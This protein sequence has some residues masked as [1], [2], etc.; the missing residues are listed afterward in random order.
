ML[1]QR[2]RLQVRRVWKHIYRSGAK[3]F[4]SVV[5]HQQPRTSRQRD[6]HTF[7]RHRAHYYSATGSGVPYIAQSILFELAIECALSDAE[8]IGYVAPVS[9]VPHQQFSDVFG[10]QTLE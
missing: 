9:P 4:I 7:T 1:K 3:Q 5:M 10:F 8:F 6:Q 2:I